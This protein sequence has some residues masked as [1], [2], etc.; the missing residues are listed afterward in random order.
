MLRDLL[1]NHKIILASGSPRRQELLKALDFDFAIDIRPVNEEYPDHLVKQEI[2]D[3]LAVLKSN[4]FQG[5]LNPQDILIT[6]DTIVWH[7]DKALGKPRDTDEAFDMLRSL[8]N[9]THEVYSSVC[10]TT[11]NSQKIVNHVTKVTF[12]SLNDD[13]IRYYIQNFKP[14]DKAGAYGIQ[15]WLGKVAVTKIDGS[16]FNVMGLPVHLVYQTLKEILVYK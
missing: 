3:Y 4:A 16:Y 2:T 11:T 5:D 7:K 6:S 10:F 14:F 15:D 9:D 1:K 12:K 13:E 8:C